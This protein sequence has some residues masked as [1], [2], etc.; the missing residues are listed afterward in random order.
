[1]S[2][3]IRNQFLTFPESFQYEEIVERIR[4]G[5]FAAVED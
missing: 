5:D 2:S 4:L 3:L 1:M